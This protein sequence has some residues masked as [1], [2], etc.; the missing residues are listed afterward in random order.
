MVCPPARLKRYL[1]M[2][3]A[4]GGLLYSHAVF[5]QV[6][7]PGSADPSRAL[8]EMERPKTPDQTLEQSE[9]TKKVVAAVPE[10]M[11]N[12]R[13]VLNEM[14]LDGMTAYE[15]G[16]VA[17]IYNRYVG[18]EIS[19]ATLFEIMTAIQQ[20]YLDD[21]YAL[22]KVVIP[23]QNIEEGNVHLAVIE[24]HV[25]EVEIDD[26][27]RKSPVI[28]DAAERIAKMRPLNVRK[29]ERLML[30]L[31]DL[32][33]S[34]VSAILATPTKAEP[35]S[36]EVRLIIQK[37]EEKEQIA[38]LAID[39]H[40]SKFT[41]PLQMKASAR[42]FHLGPNYSELSAN[43]MAAVPIDEQKSGSL[44]YTVPVFGA[45]G[46]EITV[47]SSRAHTEPGSNLSLLDIKGVSQSYSASVSY[48]IIR[49]RDMTL[50]IDSGFEWKNS[51]TK[52]LG[53]ELYDDRVRVVDVGLNFNATDSWAGYSVVDVRFSHGLNILGVR[54]AGSVDLS[55]EN[56]KPDFRKLEMLAG[57]IQAL[58]HNFELYGV[59]SGQYTNDALLSSE[60]FGFGGPNIGRG[61]DP[62]EITGDRG[63]SAAFEL[64]Y[65]M[66]STFFNK[67]LSLQPYLFYD[68]G[69]VWNIDAGAKDKVSAASAGL[70]LR[71]NIDN[72]WD[73]DLNLAKPLTRSAD[74]EPKYQ[75]DVGARVLFSLKK[76]F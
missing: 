39:N 70:G 34:N 76:S 33:D 26:K 41:G 20:K 4:L 55:R 53:E 45:S 48:P 7:L 32:P 25:G 58:P 17:P 49:Q 5:A 24:G 57:R 56:G 61:Y 37:N 9:E 64:R 40:G 66:A 29:L 72:S 71:M 54:E 65:N 35:A 59:V 18:Q 15:Y 47:S 27:I 1:L 22:T 51:R 2:A 12:L 62:S 21:G 68:I 11:E 38:S 42:A 63:I 52:I 13:F 6:D 19:V 44:S 30:I 8:E 28:E 14:Y 10:G 50:K 31:N 3:S 16:D 43:V 69:K 73:A 46:T 75:N 67:P 23:N 60:E 36:G 74:N